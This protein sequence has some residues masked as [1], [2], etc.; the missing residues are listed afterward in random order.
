ML[1]AIVE[2]I[3][4]MRKDSPEKCLHNSVEIFICNRE[5]V[6]NPFCHYLEGYVTCNNCNKQLIKFNGDVEN[7]YYYN[8]ILI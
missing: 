5:N 6:D 8:Q 1:E 7:P 4:D 3:D 2:D